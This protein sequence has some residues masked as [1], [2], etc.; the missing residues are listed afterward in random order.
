MALSEDP[1]DFAVV[2][3]ASLLTPGFDTYSTVGRAHDCDHLRRDYQFNLGLADYFGKSWVAFYL[4][5]LQESGDKLLETYKW[6]NWSWW[7]M[8]RM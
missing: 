6:A 5:T 8:L 3:L 4:L 7:V 1:R 2:T